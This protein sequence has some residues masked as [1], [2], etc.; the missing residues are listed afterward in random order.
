MGKIYKTTSNQIQL[1][2][3][4]GNKVW[5]TD[6]PPVNLL[7]ESNWL[8][9]PLTVAFPDFVKRNAYGVSTASGVFCISFITL[10]PGE[11]N[12]NG[13]GVYNLPDIV[14]GTVPNGVNYLDCR[15]N[16]N[17]TTNPSQF[18]D[19]TI[20]NLVPSGQN[21]LPGGSCL[22]ESFNLW[23]RLFEIVQIGN[24]VVMRRYQSAI[25]F[26]T[27]DFDWLPGN[28]DVF[29]GSGGIRTGYTYGGGSN[30]ELG[31]V[32]SVRDRL[33][34][35]SAPARKE[36]STGACATS[37]NTNYASTW[38]GTFTIRPGYIDPARK[39]T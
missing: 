2:D 39:V 16:L 31:L 17:R 34:S 38:T 6:T 32:L 14:L 36:R 12:R 21:Y 35:S 29:S 19:F 23:R 37:D 5:A 13:V 26:G 15:V 3:S 7:P 20:P 8:T 4:S 27:G 25:N 1:D 11:W 28:S 9:G 33:G 10:I 18:L 30:A 24:N 22:C